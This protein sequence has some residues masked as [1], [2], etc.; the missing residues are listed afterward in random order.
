[1]TRKLFLSMLVSTLLFTS[2]KPLPSAKQAETEYVYICNGPKSVVY[3]RSES[4]GGLSHCSTKVEK[5]T[6]TY[7]LKLGRRPCKIEY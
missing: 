3:H 2:F 5:V 1:M 7:A 6:L 4:C